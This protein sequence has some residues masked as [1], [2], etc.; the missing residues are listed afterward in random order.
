MPCCGRCPIRSTS[1]LH[2]LHG[3]AP[4]GDIRHDAD[5]VPVIGRELLDRDDFLEPEHGVALAQAKLLLI[6]GRA[7]SE[8]LAAC[9]IH[10]LAVE[11]IEFRPEIAR[12]RR[13]QIGEETREQ[14]GGLG[15]ERPLLR[16][17]ESTDVRFPDHAVCT[18]QQ[19]AHPRRDAPFAGQPDPELHGN[20]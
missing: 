4:R 12:I 3:G 14:P 16:S 11:A 8:R 19:G 18:F 5:Q 6:T 9:R 1:A 15:R 7:G 2:R 13:R 17:L 10:F 20:R